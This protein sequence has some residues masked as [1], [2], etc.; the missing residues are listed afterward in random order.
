MRT[1]LALV[2]LSCL[3]AADEV[4]LEVAKG[5]GATDLITS[6]NRATGLP[7][8]YPPRALKEKA[9]PA[10]IDVSLPR[11]NAYDLLVFALST[12]NLQARRYPSGGSDIEPLAVVLPESSLVTEF[13]MTG[14]DL[15]LTFDRGPGSWRSGKDLP[16]S[17]A[18]ETVRAL[19]DRLGSGAPADRARSARLLGYLGPRSPEVVQTLASQLRE[20]GVV[21]TAA[22]ALARCG[23]T[24]RPAVPALQK[25][26]QHWGAR[27]A[28]ALQRA[29]KE[30]ERSLH[31]ALL[32]PKLARETAPEHFTVRLETTRGKIDIEVTRDWSPKGADRFYNLIRIGYFDGAPFY[33][34]IKGFVAQFG[35]HPDP[36]VSRAWYTATIR[37]EPPQKPNDYGYVTFAKTDDPHSRSTEVFINL[38][39]NN[40]LDKP[41]SGFAPF[42]KVT[43]G[44]K[45]AEK[46]YGG[47]G[48]RVQAGRIH[49]DGVNYLQDNFPELDYIRRAVLVHPEK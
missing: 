30:I 35:K 46:L 3:L 11:A 1:T 25:A 16:G 13:Q 31:P 44:M 29:V 33:R 15:P 42:G 9:V 19:L 4:Q 36:R 47:Y 32:D 49:Y 7:V 17:L 18:K 14:L 22:W 2:I 24:A 45:V 40:Q 20:E 34:V 23:H 39:D 43:N 21:Q 26:I 10:R 48:E 41:Q 27:H 8:L 28:D 5:V 38:E 12:C 37:G 6:F